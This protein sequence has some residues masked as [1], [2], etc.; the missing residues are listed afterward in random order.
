LASRS[1]VS[2]NTIQNQNSESKE[3]FE[4]ELI[5]I[6]P[7]PTNSVLSIKINLLSKNK[8]IMIYNAIGQLIYE[9]TI[10]QEKTNVNLGSF[11]NGVY[12]LRILES[13]KLIKQERIVKAE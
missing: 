3:T 9:T 13:G 4:N 2:L 6:Y 7:N 5:E 1:A 8:R 11:A 10:E 12:L